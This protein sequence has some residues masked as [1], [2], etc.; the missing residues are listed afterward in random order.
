MS[1]NDLKEVDTWS[2][3]LMNVVLEY[4][5]MNIQVNQEDFEMTHKILTSADDVNF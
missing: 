1:G 5:I 3:S 2:P 4:A